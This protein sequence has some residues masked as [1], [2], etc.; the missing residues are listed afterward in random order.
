FDLGGRPAL[1]PQQWKSRED[2]DAV[3]LG[4]H[5]TRLSRQGVFN[6]VRKYA[7]LG[8]ITEISPH[9]LRHSC[10]THML[11]HGADLRVVQELLGHAS[12]S[13]TQI[14]TRVENEVLYEMYRE[15]HPRAKLK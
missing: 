15:S 5:G 11:V 14:Y 4:V 1:V 9:A 3:F 10:A 13:T 6:I 12:V 7:K 8:G 2:S